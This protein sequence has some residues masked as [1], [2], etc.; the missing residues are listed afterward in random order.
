MED[1]EENTDLAPSSAPIVSFVYFWLWKK[2]LTAHEQLT[3]L[4]CHHS[5]HMEEEVNDEDNVAPSNPSCLLKLSDSSDNN[6]GGNDI[7]DLM[8]IDDYDDNKESEESAE[9]E[10]GVMPSNITRI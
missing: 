6:Y 5:V 7:L 10:L 1:N 2:K 8:E 3:N 4:Q 9:A